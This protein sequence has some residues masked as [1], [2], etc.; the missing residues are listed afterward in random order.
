MALFPIACGVGVLAG[1]AVRHWPRDPGARDRIVSRALLGLSVT[2]IA[3]GYGVLVASCTLLASGC[4]GSAF[5]AG[6]L[7]PDL[8]ASPGDSASPLDAT[9]SPD[10]PSTASDGS[11][12]APQGH[13]SG[14][15]A[16]AQAD[17]QGDEGAPDHALLAC[18]TY[19]RAYASGCTCQLALDASPGPAGPCTADQYDD[20][21]GLDCT[22]SDLAQCETACGGF[23][24][25]PTDYLHLCTCIYACLG[26][27][28]PTN[29][30]YFE[31]RVQSCTA[32]DCP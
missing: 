26:T 9:P 5:S 11:L 19:Y 23:D 3:V 27:C 1:L 7:G 31:C 13:D 16:T 32:A 17:A 30:L 25:A 4:G 21:G 29:A 18:E 2:G 20:A 22:R 28:A 24:G 10:S 8:D 15:D 14:L 6:L 12:D